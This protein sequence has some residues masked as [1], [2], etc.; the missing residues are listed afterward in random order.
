[1]KK[2]FTLLFASISLMAAA[3]SQ[4]EN[5]QADNVNNWGWDGELLSID[6]LV[7]EVTPKGLY[8][9]VGMYFDFSVRGTNY[10]NPYDSVEIQMIFKL[11]EEVEVTDMW[12]WVYDTIVHAGM[13]DRWTANQI[14]E[15]IVDRRTD[16]AILYKYEIYDYYYDD[17]GYYS[18][19]HYS[20]HYMFRIFPMQTD[21]PR[22]AKITYLVPIEDLQGNN[23]HIPLPENIINLSDLNI[24]NCK[25][26]YFPEAG[27]GAPSITDNTNFNFN[28]VSDPNGDYYEANANN[29]LGSTNLSSLTLSM[30][31]TIS[32]NVFAGTYDDVQH[33]QKFYQL[34]IKPE[35]IFGIEQHKKA[36]ILLDF[37]DSN[38]GMTSTEVINGL[39]SQL[40]SDFDENDSINIMIS[41]MV[42][43]ILS[44]TWLPCDS[45][46][47]TDLFTNINPSSF[48]N[49][50]NLPTL[51]I[52]GID[53]IQTHGNEGSIILI[54]SANNHASL[55]EANSLMEDIFDQMGN[56]T[57]PVH[58]VDLDNVYTSG[59]YYYI[60]N[61]SYQGNEYLYTILASQTGAY[62]LRL[63]D[64]TYADML[65]TVSRR[66]SAYLT[67]FDIFVNLES[68]FTY[69]NYEIGQ[70][71]NLTWVDE[72]YSIVGKY[73][74]TGNFRITASGEAPDGELYYN[75]LLVDGANLQ[76]LDKATRSLWAGQQIREMYNYTQTN[77]VVSQIIYTSM[78]ERVLSN[79]T[80]FLALEPGEG[81]LNNLNNNDGGVIIGID[82]PVAAIEDIISFEVFPNPANE[83]A[84]LSYYLPYDAHVTLEIFD[85]FGKRIAVVDNAN[86][87][88][89][90]YKIE[91]NAAA[92]GAGTYMCRMIVDD[93]QVI[94]KKLVIVD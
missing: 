60:G 48:S 13:Y 43:N 75:E 85:L 26:K 49:F 3:Q 39:K 24:L 54:S 55:N 67:S 17:W 30:Q 47:I 27:M 12:L 52:D 9:E 35:D 28:L 44:S 66:L 68:G 53:F 21:L 76:T 69:A 8:A 2:L 86:H 91:L 59:E 41:G 18:Q 89:G 22:K 50:T 16:P 77:T 25:I 32:G 14:Y 33:S 64:E 65:E 63:Y 62:Y 58:I 45:A 82:N 1:M 15:D 78:G 40:L 11:P 19:V 94:T 92:L 81:P 29:V 10:S 5:L 80:A 72:P 84:Y 34:Q 23:P 42:T 38:S 61:H 6:T 57:I 4:Y 70:G 36:L 20:D 88:G 79:Y 37:I 46:T 31:N 51:F 90:N 56:N 74:G 7:F 71:T 83:L 93:E 87:Q 73:S